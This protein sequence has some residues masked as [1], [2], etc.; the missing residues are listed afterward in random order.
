MELVEAINI[1][2]WNL[3]KVSEIFWLD[4]VAD[5]VG[6]GRIYWSSFLKKSP[7]LVDRQIM[8]SDHSWS[9]AIALPYVLPHTCVMCIVSS[10]ILYDWPESTTV[11]VGLC[12]GSWLLGDRSITGSRR[13]LKS[14][15]RKTSRV[16]HEHAS[17]NGGFTTPGAASYWTLITATGSSSFGTRQLDME[18]GWNV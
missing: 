9:S 11:D 6:T 12:T 4:F 7:V 5:P 16:G 10:H 18:G 1:P 13:I 15:R 3:Y 17:F 2:P 8:N 14:Q